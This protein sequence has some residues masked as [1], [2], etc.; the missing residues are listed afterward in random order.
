MLFTTQLNSLN[1]SS[2]VEIFAI[3]Y[4]S[5]PDSTSHPSYFPHQDKHKIQENAYNVFTGFRRMLT[6]SFFFFLN[7]L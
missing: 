2:T 3:S 6:V 7:S 1:I 5:F 4:V